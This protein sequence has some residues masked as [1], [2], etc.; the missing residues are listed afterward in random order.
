MLLG[1]PLPAA[2]A[3]PTGPSSGETLEPSV[4]LLSF[5]P[6][7]LDAMDAIPFSP[8][9]DSED[10]AQWF[11]YQQVLRSEAAEYRPPPDDQPNGLVM[12]GDSITERLNGTC[13]GGPQSLARRDGLPEFA[14]STIRKDWRIQLHGICG[15]AADELLWRLTSGGE[16]PPRMAADSRVL[17]NLLIGTNGTLPFPQS[18]LPLWRSLRPPSAL[19]INQ[20]SQ[21][22]TLRSAVRRSR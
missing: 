12:Y 7:S 18:Q 15:E 1:F 14:S 22:S 4:A 6:A 17:F 16:L 5:F 21:Q 9:N 8:R 2:S 3:A 19:P 11:T 10:D 20:R 13:K